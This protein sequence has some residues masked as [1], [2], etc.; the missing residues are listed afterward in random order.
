MSN[1]N[2]PTQEQTRETCL[3]VIAERLTT[4]QL[5]WLAWATKYPDIVNDATEYI[6]TVKAQR[7]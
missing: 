3:K 7:K 6:K 5:Q 4:E 1:N 2:P